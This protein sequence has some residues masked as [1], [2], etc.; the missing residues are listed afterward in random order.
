MAAADAAAVE[1]MDAFRRAGLDVLLLKGPGLG[2]LLYGSAHGRSYLDVD[3]LI[4]PDTLDRAEELLATLGYRNVDAIHGVEELAGNVHAHTWLPVHAEST[5]A[6]AIDLHWTIS[7]ARSAPAVVWGAL[8]RART[9]ITL[10]G[11][12]AAVPDR[13]AQALHLAMHAAQHGPKFHKHLDELS[14][15]LGRWPREVWEAAAAL[16]Q[17]IDG[18]EPFAAG[19]R[20][21]PAGGALAS[22]LAL[23]ST[24]ELEWTIQNLDRRPRGT[25]HLRALED[26]ESR[27]E[28][29]RVLS[30]ALVPNRTWITHE[31]PWAGRGPMRLAGGYALH[32]LRAPLWATRAWAY[33]RR[34]R[35]ARRRQR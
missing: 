33:S 12:R 2:H 8:W 10:A 29:V 28:Q 5:G 13:S 18:L 1:A 14:L 7:G 30:R 4:A 25:F 26:A 9:E 27:A 20:L 21:V 23:P 15:A 19:L 31:H 6:S 22:Q 32:I 16:A 24:H 35:R 17:E 11:N 34:A 3:L